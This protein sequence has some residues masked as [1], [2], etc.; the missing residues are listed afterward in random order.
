[1]DKYIVAIAPKKAYLISGKDRFEADLVM[2]AY[3]STNNNISIQANGSGVPVNQGIGHYTGG[4]ETGAG[5]KTFTATATISNPA[6]GEK[7][8]VKGEFKYEVGQASCTVAADKMNVFYIGVPNP[9]SISAAG[10]SSNSM[11]V[12][13]NGGGGSL[14]GSGK[15]YVVTVNSPGD[16]NIV[17]SSPELGSPATFKFRVK[18][19]PDP[20]PKL[21]LG[22]NSGGGRMGNGEFKAQGGLI[23]YLAN[24]DFEA[25]CNIQSF[26]TTRI[27][28]RQDP[29]PANNEGGT[30]TGQ[31][32]ELINQAKPGDVYFFDEIKARC[33]GDAAGRPI[34]SLSFTIK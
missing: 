5:E 27:A 12:S 28:K 14:S 15:S 32:K 30:F 23:A 21:G 1:M 4:V 31:S 22:P 24:F 8:S 16:A 10:V 11:K 25:R 2:G 34:G 9:I 33:P 6:T 7:T 19:I 29:V 17:I 13:I 3:S 18:R 20:V 26:I